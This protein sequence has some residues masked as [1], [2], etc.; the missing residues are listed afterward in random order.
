M[1]L[2][3]L[4]QNKKQKCVAIVTKA[5]LSVSGHPALLLNMGVDMSELVSMDI[6]SLESRPFCMAGA[7]GKGPGIN[8]MHMRSIQVIDG[9]RYI[10][11][12][13]HS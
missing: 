3:K 1:N 4:H 8:C 11:V 10:L 13:V 7:L 9:T 5:T 2:I 6:S 12:H